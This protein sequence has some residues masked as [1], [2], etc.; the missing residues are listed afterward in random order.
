MPNH[1]VTIGLCGR[2][3]DKSGEPVDLSEI[4]GTNLCAILSPLPEVMINIVSTHPPCRYIHKTTGEVHQS[5]NGPM[6]DRN[7]WQQVPLTDKEVA[8][9]KEKYDAV[10]WYDWQIQ[11]WG[12]KW[13]TYDT[14]VTEISGDGAPVLIEFQS[15]WGPPHPEMMRKIDTY[16][17]DK[18][19][20]KN[21]K[22]I[23]HDPYDGSTCEI[24]LASQTTET[25][26][27]NT[28]RRK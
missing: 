8:E 4:N 3:W 13:G 10:T 1:F 11:E 26:D 16:L 24:K 12:T 17:C 19:A 21:I 5:C 9:L 23:G 15:A 14:K 7:Q 25:A 20:L 6:E 22:W 28:I 27:G 2:D 18:Y